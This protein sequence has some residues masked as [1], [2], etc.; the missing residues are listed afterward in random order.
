MCVREEERGSPVRFDDSLSNGI[1]NLVENVLV[2]CTAYKE[3]ILENSK[4]K[5]KM[6]DCHTQGS[7]CAHVPL[8]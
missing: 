6:S 5:P 7:Y 8:A 3:L 2:V 4:T 1:A